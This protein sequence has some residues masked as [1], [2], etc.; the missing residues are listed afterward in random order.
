MPVKTLP[1]PGAKAVLTA[2]VSAR[3]VSLTTT[4]LARLPAVLTAVL[5]VLVPRRNARA[6]ANVSNVLQTAIARTA[7][8]VSAISVRQ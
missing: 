2:L 6:A 8:N 1:V 4:E 7:R 5:A 3:A